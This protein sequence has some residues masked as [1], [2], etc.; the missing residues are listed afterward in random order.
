MAAGLEVDL[1]FCPKVECRD[2]RSVRHVL[3]CSLHQGPFILT[4]GVVRWP[5]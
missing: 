5:M 3:T 4:C 1:M 2:G